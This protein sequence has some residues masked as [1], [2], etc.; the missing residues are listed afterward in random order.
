LYGIFVWARRAL[1][2]PKRWFPARAAAKQAEIAALAELS[3]LRSQL[4]IAQ[5]SGDA[6]RETSQDAAG[7]SKDAEELG[8]ELA[9]V[10]SELVGAKKTLS[11]R[12][13][14]DIEERVLIETLRRQVRNM[15][16][17]PRSWANFNLYTSPVFP[18][19]CMGQLAYFRPT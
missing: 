3:G 18:P 16:S 19:E 14:E 1:N 6:H 17:W 9:V 4:A 7:D 11:A 2:S 10:K 13:M 15:P 12:R 8:I 5:Q